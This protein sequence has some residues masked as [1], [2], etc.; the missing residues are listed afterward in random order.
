MAAGSSPRSK[1]WYPSPGWAVSLPQLEGIARGVSEEPPHSKWRDE[2]PLHKALM[3]SQQ[4]A[5]T[6]DSE[7]VWKVREDYFKTNHP[8]FDCETSHDLMDV[9]QDMITSASLLG[10][11]IY[12][13]QEGWGGQSKL[14]YANNAL[15]TLPKG[16]QFFHP[17]SP[18][19]LPKVMGLAGI[20]NPDALLCFNS[21]TFCPWCG[22][23]GQNEGTIVNHLW[24]T[25]YKLGL[26]CGTCFCCL[27]VSSKAIW[28]HG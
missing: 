4:E 15:K 20:H 21:I 25:H 11:Q 9:F 19:E 22:K 7:L 24:M 14:W 8:H 16:V 5:F 1:W 18:L 2:T 6:R 12:P 3:G 13:I 26:V 17:V 10:S 28:C 27:S 23:E